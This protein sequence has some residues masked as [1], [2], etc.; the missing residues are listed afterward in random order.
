MEVTLF[1]SSNDIISTAHHLVVLLRRRG[2]VV[3]IHRIEYQT[4]DE[5]AVP[6]MDQIV[7]TDTSR[8]DDFGPRYIRLNL[9]SSSGG[10]E[11]EKKKAVW[12]VLAEQK[13]TSDE[14]VIDMMSHSHYTATSAPAS[15]P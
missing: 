11:S 14:V 8:Q 15:V 1:S 5:V 7:Q 6:R 9:L 13:E 3:I 12:N 2:N 4:Y 10:F